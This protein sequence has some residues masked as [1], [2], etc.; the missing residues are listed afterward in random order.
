MKSLSYDSELCVGC[1]ICEEVCSDTWFKVVDA[2]KSSIRILDG[3][4]GLL[5][6]IYC[7]QCGECIDVCPTEALYRDKR[8]IVRL[9][10][11]L[12]VGCLSCVGFCRYHAMLYHSDQPEPFKC[13]ACGR[14]VKECPA[15]ALATVDVETGRAV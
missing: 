15:D 11:A 3:D 6:A 5:T 2:E 10:K 9:K 8:G 12:C 13:I 4:D 1:G 14:C 7:V